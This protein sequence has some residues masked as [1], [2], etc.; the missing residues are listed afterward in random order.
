MTWVQYKS[1][2]DIS[3]CLIWYFTF[4]IEWRWISTC[5]L[6]YDVHVITCT[7]KFI[8]SWQCSIFIQLDE[9]NFII[10]IPQY[11]YKE[12]EYVKSQTYASGWK[13]KG[14][15]IIRTY[16]KRSRGKPKDSF[17]IEK[18]KINLKHEHR[19]KVLDTNG[20]KSGNFCCLGQET[21]RSGLLQV[22]EIYQETLHESFYWYF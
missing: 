11:S 18:R 22:R 16:S 5:S 10:L 13:P 1:S 9:C 4:N 17:N 3:Q 12:F 19:G 2:C 14:V 8:K 7:H 6:N 20:R 21:N 15:L